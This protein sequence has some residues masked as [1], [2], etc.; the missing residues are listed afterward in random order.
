MKGILST[1]AINLSQQEEHIEN[2]KTRMAKLKELMF[3][4]CVIMQTLCN[5][6]LFA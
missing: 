6:V 4:N 3:N 5:Y 1:K 2:E